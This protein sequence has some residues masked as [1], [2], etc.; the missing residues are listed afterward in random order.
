MSQADYYQNGNNFTCGTF[1]DQQQSIA[2]TPLQD[3]CWFGNIFVER[4]LTLLLIT[5]SAAAE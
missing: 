5:L 4:C 1:H 2:L 3:D